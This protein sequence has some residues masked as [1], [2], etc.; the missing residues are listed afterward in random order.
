MKRAFK[1]SAILALL[2]STNGAMGAE[3]KITMEEA[4]KKIAIELDNPKTDYQVRLIDM[5]NHVIY[6]KWVKKNEI[7]DKRL[8][9]NKLAFGIYVLTVENHLRVEEFVIAIEKTKLSLVSNYTKFKPAFRKKDG[10]I[11]LNLLNL[12]LNPVSIEV[13]DAMDRLLFSETMDNTLDVSKSFNFEKAFSGSYI[14]TVGDGASV[15]TEEV[16]V[17]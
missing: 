2:F 16:N 11:Y 9:L 10:R 5:D 3:P 13:H 15:Y 6:S 7:R 14:I 12:D 17:Y 1:F 4:R 8:D